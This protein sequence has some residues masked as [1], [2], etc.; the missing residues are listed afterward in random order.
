MKLALTVGTPV[1]NC[2]PLCTFRLLQNLNTKFTQIFRFLNK[3]ETFSEC[4]HN[5]NRKSSECALKIMQIYLIIEKYHF[6]HCFTNFPS[7]SE[8]KLHKTLFLY[9]F[10]K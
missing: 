3:F 8:N 10:G 6:T 1:S 4:I 9:Y 5:L 2:E 7:F